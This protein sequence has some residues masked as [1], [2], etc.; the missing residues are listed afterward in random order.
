MVIGTSRDFSSRRCA[1]TTISCNWLPLSAAL[2]SA[3]PLSVSAIAAATKISV[4]AH[5]ITEAVTRRTYRLDVIHCSPL[6]YLVLLQARGQR[7]LPSVAL[8]HLTKMDNQGGQ[9]RRIEVA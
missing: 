6:A 8:R 1:L 2:C 3:T 5:A 7:N 9:G 4:D